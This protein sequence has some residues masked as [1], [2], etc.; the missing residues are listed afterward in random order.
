VTAGTHLGPTVDGLVTLRGP[1]ASTKEKASVAA[2]AEK[3]AGATTATATDASKRHSNSRSNSSSGKNNACHSSSSNSLLISNNNVSCSTV[4]IYCRG[5]TATGTAAGRAAT[6]RK[7]YGA[8]PLSATVLLQVGVRG[9]R[10]QQMRVEGK[11]LDR[12]NSVGTRCS[13]CIGSAKARAWIAER[14]SHK[15]LETDIVCRTAARLTPHHHL[16]SRRS[17]VISC[18]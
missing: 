7:A 4:D 18:P 14:H 15:E 11:P 10:Q 2:K 13:I 5:A 16:V 6:A 8:V 9:L 3:V 12:H 17:P 1:V